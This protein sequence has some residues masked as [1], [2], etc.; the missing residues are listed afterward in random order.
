M[1]FVVTGSNLLGLTTNRLKELAR[2]PPQLCSVQP[3][4]MLN[5]S[6]EEPLENLLVS[7]SFK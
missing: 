4:G 7:R 2:P 3:G 5:L 6:F 1:W